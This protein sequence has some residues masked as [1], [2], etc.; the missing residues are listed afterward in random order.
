VA[1]YG[2]VWVDATITIE[3]HT[4]L[5]NAIRSAGL[6]P[7]QVNYD[8]IL[9]ML[10]IVV[11]EWALFQGEKIRY[12]SIGKQLFAGP[13]VLYHVDK[14]GGIINLDMGD[15]PPVMFYGSFDEV[16]KVIEDGYITRPA[17]IY[18]DQILWRWPDP[19]GQLAL[20]RAGELAYASLQETL[21]NE[22]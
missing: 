16:E 4:I 14:D 18:G 17:I 7:G 6:T 12:F 13:A 2:I 3:E 22:K 9:P 21:R 5:D 10:G 20:R 1:T 15:L 8:I 11:Y 19:N